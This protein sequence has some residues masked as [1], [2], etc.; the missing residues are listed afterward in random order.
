[1]SEL[2]IYLIGLGLAFY[3]AWCMGTNDAAN[4]TDCAVGAGVINLRKAVL[5]FA[6]FVVLGA[7]LQGSMVMK[8]VGEG[9][10]PGGIDL[11]GAFTA[12]LAV[13]IWITFCS[14]K[15]LPIS[16]THSIVGAVVGYGLVTGG[17]FGLSWWVV[18]MILIGMI[19]SPILSIFLSMGL[20]PC[21]KGLF[22]RLSRW[23]TPDEIERL[24]GGMIVFA[25]CF[26]A[27]SF[28]ANDVANATG[29]FVTVTERLGGSLASWSMILLAALGS[30]GVAIGG[31]T[32]GHRVIETGARRIT[33]LNPLTGLSAEFSNAITVFGFTT[34]P[35]ILFGWGLP[36]ST[37][38]SSI[39]SIVGVGLAGEG[40]GTDKKVVWKIVIFW[41]LTLP[42][43]ILMSVGLYGVV[44]MI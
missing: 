8:T 39:G 12:I 22:E 25:L 7:L 40:A 26:S 37:T 15:G 16:T 17:I 42:A 14:W 38:H 41:I 2:P 1:M 5:L 28:G 3:V 32:W 10:V 29:I 18:L 23:M 43:T 21:F 34:I 33:H 13:C 36:I 31:L 30:L 19:L 4:P 44:S 6:A 11:L 9:I 20:L 24:M 27:Y 35:F